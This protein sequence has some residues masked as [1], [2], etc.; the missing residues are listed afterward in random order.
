MKK[1]RIAIIGGGAAGFFAAINSAEKFRNAEVTLLEQGRQVLSKVRISGGGRCNV[2]H[3]CFD[4]ALLTSFYPR[5]GKALRGA[6][7]QF[8]PRDTVRWFTSRGVAL[9]T[10]EDGRMFPTTDSSETI[11]E[12]LLS[13]AHQ[14]GVNVCTERQ[15][16]NI[17]RR[18]D[19]T[20]EIRIKGYSS[21]I[22]DRVLCTT[23]SQQKIFSMLKQLGHT[24]CEP[25][26]SLFTFPIK[27]TRLENLEGI[28]VS[29]CSVKISGTSIEQKGPILI[30]HW[31]LSGPAILKTSAWGARVLHAK[32]Y[33]ATLVI[34]W[35]ADMHPEKIQ[36]FLL[37]KKI[38]HP[39]KLICGDIDLSIPNKLWKQLVLHSNISSELRW[40][41]ISKKQ[42]HSL[43][44]NLTRCELAISGKTTYKSEFV[45][46]GGVSLDEI[47]FKTMES[48]LCKGLYFA[49]EVID[50]D[51]VTGGFNFQNAWTTGWIASQ[52]IGN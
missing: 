50:V 30:T 29:S 21:L 47:H 36:H 9:K 6:F 2:T 27:D 44:Q 31:G 41:N 28:S 1:L 22:A 15:V 18:E 34:N 10:E 11:I 12:C 26:P 7:S 17:V 3:A 35:L 48:K 16:E 23:G 40:I 51:G 49:G 8:Q 4:P 42:L 14:S 13:A 33:Q 32:N 19:G 37:E 20:F 5:G 45:T 24:I 52:S 25:V 43:I 39:Q 46:C 38:S